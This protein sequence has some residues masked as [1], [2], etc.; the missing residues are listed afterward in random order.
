MRFRII[1]CLAVV[2]LWPSVPPSFAQPP[3]KW[4][5][6]YTYQYWG[7]RQGLPNAQ[8]H[9]S[10][11][12]SYGYMWFSTQSGVSRFD[13]LHFDHFFREE[14]GIGSAR[15]KYFN[16]YG[17]AVYM[18]SQKNITFVYPDRTIENYPLP[19]S[20]LLL[21]IEKQ[22]AV[23]ADG[24]NLYIFN[25]QS[26]A[27]GN[28]DLWSHIKFDMKNKTFTFVSETSTPLDPFTFE[29]KNY[30]ISTDLI[31]DRQ[32]DVYQIE[33]NRLRLIQTIQME[34]SDLVFENQCKNQPFVLLLKGNKIEKTAHLYQYC[35]QN[36]T[37]RLI[38]RAPTPFVDVTKYVMT[39]DEHRLFVTSDTYPHPVFVYNIDTGI[40]SEFPLSMQ[41]VN[42]ICVDRD[43]N[44]WFSTEDGV[45]QCSRTFF[46]SFRLGLGTNDNIWGV[47]RDSR[48][49][50]WLSSFSYG[51]WRADPAGNL[52]RAKTLYQGKDYPVLS[53]GYMGSCLDS[54]GRFF[55]T[56]HSGVALFDPAHKDPNRLDI[57]PTGVSL[58]LY[59]D[60]ESRKTY[61]GGYSG[62]S[63]TLNIIDEQ[64]ILVSASSSRSHIVSICRDGNGRLRLGF[65]STGGAWF[66]EENGEI[67]S[68][69]V[70][71]SYNGIISMSLDDNGTLWKGTTH[72]VFAED[73]HGNDTHIAS[74]KMVHFLLH[75]HNQYLIYGLSDKLCLLD[76][77]AYY[78]DSTISVRQFGYFDGFDVMECGQNGASIDHDG[79]VWVTGTD[80]VIRFM[81]E[82]LMK[83]PL[84]QPTA[85]HLAAIYNA[86][87]SGVWTQVADLTPSR[88]DNR[89]N[90]LR[91]DLLQAIPSSPDKLLFR[92]RLIGYNDQWV[93]T[94]ERSI[95]F[96]NLS[97]GK[98][99]FEVQSSVDQAL[100]SESAFSPSITIKAS[101]LLSP[102]GLLMIIAV[103]SGL[104][105]LIVYWT[106]KIIIKQEEEKRRIDQ[107][108]LLAIRAK[109]IPHFTGNVLNSINYLIQKEPYDAQRYISD[110][111]DFSNMT[112]LHSDSLF[113]PIEEELLYAELYLKLE[114]LRF[115]ER[116]TY[117]VSVA[118]GVNLQ[119]DVPCMALQTFCENALKHGLSSKPDGGSIDLC[120]YRQNDLTVLSV[121]DN[122]IGRQKAKALHT[123]GTGEGLKIVQQQLDL[124][125]KGKTN[126]AFMQII[127]LYDPE[128]QATGTRV[129]VV[130]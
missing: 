121:Q 98:Y 77:Q 27:Q 13:G 54:L 122:G 101:F 33:D 42:H 130:V 45:Y 64:G 125:N 123:G 91:F 59:H 46:E 95:T 40:F 60:N 37:L 124:M 36:D 65:F 63:P 21:N 2:L 76:L 78:K 102:I 113:R 79:Y 90:S 92:Y 4:E 120:V 111:S 38:D 84:L 20:T 89:D 10:Y 100:W 104:A 118:E 99:Q 56:Y 43:Q 105:L 103:I 52:Y 108:T 48:H 69:T 51:L 71:R 25:C 93:T 115:G 58:A 17:S 81:P 8:V 44:L 11:Q 26:S 28:F 47:I 70:Q 83:L 107:L 80:K 114:K 85:P 14:L 61:F 126:K 34:K 110:F 15:V 53:Q 66:D 3:Q 18:L 12:D 82:Q 32:I 106:R 119:L 7:T 6:S 19:D 75:Y 55:L 62:I 117:H 57:I 1:T 16:Q 88:L 109:F 128:G 49:N 87:K 31:H 129:E 74:D 29:G 72:G 35:I 9:L 50:T 5:H 39:W 23:A 127:D 30:A 68:D 96:Q 116:L 22:S 73:L 94:P 112:L 86:N 97:F 41:R 67:V 24:D